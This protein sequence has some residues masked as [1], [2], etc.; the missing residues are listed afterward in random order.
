[1]PAFGLIEERVVGVGHDRHTAAVDAPAIVERVADRGCLHDDVI[2]RSKAGTANQMPYGPLHASG[3][4]E[5]G[6]PG[7]MGDEAGEVRETHDADLGPGRDVLRAEEAERQVVER[8]AAC[9]E[10][11]G[12]VS[13]F[14]SQDGPGARL[15]AI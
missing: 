2:S 7:K 8:P 9:T 14:D 5:Q 13:L 1:L 4:V 15:Y 11:H 3:D 12:G 6:R 10:I